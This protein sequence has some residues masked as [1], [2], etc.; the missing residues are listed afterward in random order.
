MTCGTSPYRTNPCCPRQEGV[1]AA[2]TNPHRQGAGK[3]DDTGTPG[4]GTKQA[5]IRSRTAS[6][7]KPQDGR[8][9]DRGE[10]DSKEPLLW[11]NAPE[12]TL[13][14][15]NGAILQRPAAFLR[16]APR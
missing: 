2:L 8:K 1:K 12:G 6:R 5:A 3:T 13:R 10:D 14:D 11:N 15:H 9:N 16:R 7:A 4:C